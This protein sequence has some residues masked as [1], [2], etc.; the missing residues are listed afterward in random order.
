MMIFRREMRRN[1][2]GL[3]IWSVVIGAYILMLLSMYPQFAADQQSI[4]QLM[5]AFP[6]SLKQAFGMDTLHFGSAL[7][8]Y[9]VQIYLFT[10]LIGSVYAAMLAGGILAK[11]EGEKTA[12]FL[13]SKP[14]SRVSVAGQKL[15]AIFLNLLLFNAVL[16]AASAAGFRIAGDA[17]AAGSSIFVLYVLAAFLLHLTFAAIAFLLSS[18]LRKQR[19][20]VSFALGIVFLS[21]ALHIAAGVSESVSALG[22]LSFFRYVDAALIM[23]EESIRGTYIAVMLIV[24]AACLTAATLYYKKKD[25]A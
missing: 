18:L 21:Y 4:D 25:I 15:G 8:Y 6:E 11:E 20:I 23:E 17:S 12:E 16:A 10:T 2:K 9:G 3:L 7:G 24:S 19:S 5:Q 22:E 13:L 14:V 1:R